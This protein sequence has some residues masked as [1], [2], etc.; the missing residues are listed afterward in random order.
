VLLV[1]GIDCRDQFLRPLE[2]AVKESG[3]KEVRFASYLPRH[4]EVGIDKIAAQ[5]AE[6]ALKLKEETESDKI[7]IV[8]FSM[9]ALASRYFI[10][11]LGG[12]DYVR[13]FVSISGPHNGTYAGYLRFFHRGVRDMWPT[14]DLIRDLNTDEDPWGDVHVYSFYTPFDWIVVPASTAILRNSVE[15]K[16]FRVALHHQMVKDPHVLSEVIKVLRKPHKAKGSLADNDI[17]KIVGSS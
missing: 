12:K 3:V 5:I 15:V 10:Q 1:R 16:S 11:R 2:K 14:S 7:D 4:G 8:G 13:K 6:A 9:G 17:A